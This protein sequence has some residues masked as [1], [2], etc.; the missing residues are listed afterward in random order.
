M[1]SSRVVVLPEPDSPTIAMHSPARTSNEMWF[2]ACTVPMRRFT[3]APFVRGNSRC[4]FSTSS[5]T[6]R[7]SRGM[8]AY[9]LSGKTGAGN[10]G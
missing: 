5:V 3:S 8:P 4:R 7:S 1:I 10:S 6:S 2:T 9:L